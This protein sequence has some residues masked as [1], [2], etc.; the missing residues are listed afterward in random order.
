MIRVLW[1]FCYHETHMTHL[2]S[3]M[4]PNETCIEGVIVSSYEYMTHMIIYSMQKLNAT[5]SMKLCIPEHFSSRAGP[6]WKNPNDFGMEKSCP[7]CRTGQ[8]GS[9][10]FGPGSGRLS[11]PRNL[12]Y[13]IAKNV[14]QAEFGSKIILS[15][16]EISAQDLS[17]KVCGRAK[18]RQARARP[19]WASFA[20][21]YIFSMKLS[22]ERLTVWW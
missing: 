12:Y 19:G 16:C 3:P 5:S 21:V 11:R 14:Y 10:F 4:K 17:V 9:T 13:K 22:T 7:W 18:A 20:Q 8:V 6:G 2:P 1:K 15:C